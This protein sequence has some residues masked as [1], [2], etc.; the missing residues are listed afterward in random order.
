M[1][2]WKQP[3]YLTKGTVKVYVQY[4]LLKPQLWDHTRYVNVDVD[5]DN[6]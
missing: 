5:S 6:L 1:V 2:Y 3:F 4:I